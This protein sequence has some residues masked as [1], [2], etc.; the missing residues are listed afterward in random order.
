[1]LSGQ[2]GGWEITKRVN[3]DLLLKGGGMS[4]GT[5]WSKGGLM[6]AR[7]RER[8]GNPWRGLSERKSKQGDCLPVGAEEEVGRV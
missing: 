8:R 3:A 6:K 7:T 1:M 4:A 2:R 5:S